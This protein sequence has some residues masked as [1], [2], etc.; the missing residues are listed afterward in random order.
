MNK[1]IA[2]GNVRLKRA[3]ERGAAADGT[4]IPIGSGRG[5][6]KADGGHCS[7]GRGSLS[8]YR[9]T[10]MVRAR[11]CP[12]TRIRRRYAGEMRASTRINSTCCARWH[13]EGGSQL[14]S[15]HMTRFTTTLWHCE[16]FFWC[17]R[18]SES[19]SRLRQ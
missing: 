1:R 8:Q 5:V 4:W 13:D 12:L 9:I 16:T 11:P 19:P 14:S 2:A 17:G 15:P 7:I 10:E 3:Y 18:G 6:R